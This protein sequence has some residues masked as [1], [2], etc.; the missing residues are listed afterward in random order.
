MFI[1]QIIV[2][3]III[4]LFACT[5]HAQLPSPKLTPGSSY[6]HILLID[7]CHPEYIKHK[8]IP[9]NTKINVMARYNI[10]INLISKYVIDFL[11]PESLGG[12]DSI[13]NLWPQSVN[14]KWGFLKKNEL[15]NRL[16]KLVCDGIID[17]KTARKEISANWIEAYKT[18]VDGGK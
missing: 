3:A 18:Y 17:L 2:S 10:P 15:E 14:G 11:I 12:N 13:T 5:I 8:N 6:I 4:L 9:W 1:K 16:Q 7:V